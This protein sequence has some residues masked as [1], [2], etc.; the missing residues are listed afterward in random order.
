ML[1]PTSL[2]CSPLHETAQL[3]G[4]SVATPV[5]TL[6][7]TAAFP[8]CYTA[9]GVLYDVNGGCVPP[10]APTGDASTYD[11]CFCNDP[12]LSSFRSSPSGLCSAACVATADAATIQNWFTS[13]CNDVA[14]VDPAAATTTTSSSSST[15]TAASGASNQSGG[16]NK[17]WYATPLVVSGVCPHVDVPCHSI[18]RGL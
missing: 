16:G 17:T 12:R 15:S 18:P 3:T 6:F 10:A 2:A 7:P 14:T 11:S 9:C 5:T 13:F 4:V 8:S 1:Q